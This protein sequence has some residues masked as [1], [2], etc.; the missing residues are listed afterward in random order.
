MYCRCYK[1]RWPGYGGDLRTV[2]RIMPVIGTSTAGD[3]APFRREVTGRIPG[4]DRVAR[5]DQHDLCA[6]GRERLVPLSLRHDENLAWAE[7]HLASVQADRQGSLQ[8][9]EELVRL[10]VAVPS[11]LALCADDPYVVVIHHRD[12]A[13]RPRLGDGCE[14]GIEVHRSSHEAEHASQLLEWRKLGVAIRRRITGLIRAGGGP[15]CPCV[16]TTRDQGSP[17]RSPSC[18]TPRPTAC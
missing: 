9:Q 3:Y 8:D 2:G 13:R 18:R 10:R 14:D 16:Q 7:E 17:L 4:V 6:I 1:M 11:E 5:L 15:P 12:R